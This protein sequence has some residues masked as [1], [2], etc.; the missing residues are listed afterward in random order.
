MSVRDGRK[1]ADRNNVGCNQQLHNDRA[2][3]AGFREGL[4][5]A[6]QRWI[7]EHEE[8]RYNIY[9]TA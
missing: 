6:R 8:M 4:L 7:D 3:A 2:V 1:K 5:F 9:T